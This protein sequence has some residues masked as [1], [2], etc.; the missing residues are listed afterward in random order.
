[1]EGLIRG[2]QSADG[3]DEELGEALK[4]DEHGGLGEEAAEVWGGS[5]WLILLLFF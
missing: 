3:E 2:R 5:S 4:D 1:M